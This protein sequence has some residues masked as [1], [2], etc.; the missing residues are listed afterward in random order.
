[1]LLRRMRAAVAKEGPR[2]LQ[3]G[4]AVCP[5]RR[6][7]SVLFEAYSRRNQEDPPRMSGVSAEPGNLLRPRQARAA[8]RL[9]LPGGTLYGFSP[10]WLPLFPDGDSLRPR[11]RYPVSW[12]HGLFQG[13]LGRLRRLEVAGANAHGNRRLRIAGRE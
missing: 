5:Q 1:M 12:L 3:C 13:L 7:S 11:L 4:R 8:R 9:F 2:S 6:A 10:L